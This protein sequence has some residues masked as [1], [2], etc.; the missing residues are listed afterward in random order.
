MSFSRGRME[1]DAVCIVSVGS[2][3]SHILRETDLVRQ[4]GRQKKIDDSELHD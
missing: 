3:G 1:A 4:G 2:E